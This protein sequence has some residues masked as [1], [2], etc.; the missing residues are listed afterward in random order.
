MKR[1]YICCLA[2]G[3]IACVTHQQFV[4]EVHL[5]EGA[6]LNSTITSSKPM[7]VKPSTDLDLS[8]IPSI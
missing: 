6:T 1:I 3:L 4:T 2:I 7:D 8:M 5:A